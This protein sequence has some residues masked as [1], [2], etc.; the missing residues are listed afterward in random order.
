MNVLASIV[1][2]IIE[3]KKIASTTAWI[4]LLTKTTTK[5]NYLKTEET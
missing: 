1:L 2:D 4:S 5:E 3:K